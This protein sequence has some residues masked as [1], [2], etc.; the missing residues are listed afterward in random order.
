V[1]AT[2]A[3]PDSGPDAVPGA[4]ADI[5][6][7]ADLVDVMD[8]LRSPGGCPWDAEQ[9][10]ESLLPYAVEEVF[11]VVEAVE[12]GDRAALLE[13]LGDLLL[14]VVFHA[15]VA[16]EHP[17]DPFG[18]DDVAAGVA[19]KLR[20]RH[21]HVFGDVEVSGSAEV[22]TNWERIKK[23]EKSRES[24]LDGIPAGMPALARAEKVAG[25][26][27]RAGLAVDDVVRRLA[28]AGGGVDDG[29][30]VGRTP[31]DGA[32]ADGAPA[33]GVPDAASSDAALSDAVSPDAV[34]PDAATRRT[35]RVLLAIA[36]EAQ[37]AG[38]D[39]EAALRGAVRDLEDALRASET[40]APNAPV[41]DTGRGIN[42]SLD[43]DSVGT[44][45]LA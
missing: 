8:R 39:A 37:A 25:R 23:A 9:T 11:E 22:H 16:A 29:A 3:A 35:G 20:R 24:A 19:A 45:D 14:Q 33:D 41:P 38:I 43:T 2:D 4:A 6:A 28:S 1:T 30:P 10:H 40:L 15:R 12:T 26:A 13:E 7:L 44:P 27:R 17:T 18:I 21:P 36:L 42:R 5:A 31:A 32:P 34:S